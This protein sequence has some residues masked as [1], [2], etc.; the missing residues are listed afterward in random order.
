MSRTLC[1]YVR[2]H[3]R[4]RQN[5]QIHSAKQGYEP[6]GLHEELCVGRT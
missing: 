3:V 4:N 6:E 2:V 5:E 1:I